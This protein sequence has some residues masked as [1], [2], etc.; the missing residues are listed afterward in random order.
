MIICRKELKR[1]AGSWC[2]CTF[3]LVFIQSFICIFL[4]PEVKAQI[5]T[6]NDAMENVG[7]IVGAFGMDY[8]SLDEI[9]DFYGLVCGMALGIGGGLFAATKGACI[10]EAEEENDTADFLLTFPIS[11]AAVLTQK[12]FALLMQ[13]IALNAA[14]MGAGLLTVGIL[15]DTLDMRCFTL[16]H[17]IYLIMQ[18]EVSGIC[19]GISAF[20]K[21]GGGGIGAVFVVV[22]YLVNM[23]YNI[24]G[25]MGVLKYLTPYAYCKVSRI[26][27]QAKIQ[28]ELIGIGVA[29]GALGIAVAYLKYARKDIGAAN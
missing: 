17:I 26:F 2:M 11:R 5:S 29:I 8:L 21:T 4:F 19:F 15:N 10:L 3:A 14:V 1:A 23:I 6:V 24:S 18:L 28:M 9:T 7:K 16:L 25:N 22:L 12:L 20:I 13:V 27:S